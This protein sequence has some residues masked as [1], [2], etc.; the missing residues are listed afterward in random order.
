MCVWYQ[1]FILWEQSSWVMKLTTHIHLV[2]RL[3]MH[4]FTSTRGELSMDTDSFTF[5]I[6]Q[7]TNKTHT[8]TVFT[9]VCP[10]FYLPMTREEKLWGC[11]DCLPT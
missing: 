2:P 8:D 1:E 5:Y 3:K 9:Y 7:L 10:T 4:D 6:L 11:A